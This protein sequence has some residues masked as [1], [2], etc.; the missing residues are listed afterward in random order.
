MSLGNADDRHHLEFM[1]TSLFCDA[2]YRQ[3]LD[4]VLA[5]ETRA[6]SKEMI[7]TGTRCAIACGDLE[8]SLKLARAGSQYVRLL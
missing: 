8:N 7:D 2:Q 4:L 1:V 3:A 5:V 6:L